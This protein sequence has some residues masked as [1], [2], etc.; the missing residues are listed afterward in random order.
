M[1]IDINLKAD[2]IANLDSKRIN[3]LASFD[4]HAALL[5]TEL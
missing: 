2:Y 1:K 3:E 4:G 5:Q